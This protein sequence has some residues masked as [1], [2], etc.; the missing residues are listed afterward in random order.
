MINCKLTL[1]A[2]AALALLLPTLLTSCGDEDTVAV[3]ELTRTDVEEIVRS[4]V[5]RAT[6][7]SD[8]SGAEVERIVNEAVADLPQPE[9]TRLDVEQIVQSAIDAAMIQMSAQQS[10]DTPL[11]P[12]DVEQIVQAAIADLPESQPSLTA[13]EIQA[14]IQA[15][16]P[17]PGPTLAE[18]EELLRQA[19]SKA[20]EPGL[21][22]EEVRRLA[23]NAVASIP[24]RSSPAEFTKFFVQ[25]AISRYNEEGLPSTIAHYS[26]RPSVDGQ[27]FVFIVDENDKVIAHHNPGL[28]GEDL[29]GPFGVDANGYS[30]GRDFLSATEQGKWVSYVSRNPETG[31][32]GD[33]EIK[34]VWVVKQDD[35]LFASGWHINANDFTTQL[36]SVAIDAFRYGG[37]QATLDHFASPDSALAGLETA[38]AYYNQ[39]ESVDG[40]WSVFIANES[41]RFVAHSNP[42]L[43]GTGAEE[44]FGPEI[45]NAPESGTW[46]TT[47][48]SHVYVASYGGLIFGSGWRQGELEKASLVDRLK[49]NANEFDYAI[50]NF[51]GTLTFATISEPLTLNLAIASDASSSGVL[52][53]L[54]EGLTTT[55]WL[56]NKVEPSLAKSWQHS[57]DGLTWTFHLRDDVRWHD[58]EPFTAHD[59]AF[60]FNRIIYNP[61]I[62]AS[63]R[64]TF[65]FRTLNQETG[66]WEESPMTVR[67]LDD[68]TVEC[69]LPVP[70]A[71]FLRSMGTAI[72][73]RHI[74]ETHVDDG[75][76]TT[77]WDIETDPAEIIGTG[78]FTIDSYS[79]GEHVIMKRN[80]DYWLKDAEGNTLPY[81]DRIIH[82][83][84]SDLEEEIDKFLDGD[85]DVHGVL[86]EEI[87]ILAPLQKE[88]NF[89][90]H[91]RGPAFGTA[92]MSFNMNPGLNPDTGVPYLSPE[93]LEWFRNRQFRQAVAHVIDKNKIIHQ[94]QH[95]AG[96][97]QWSSVSPAAGDFHNPNVTQYE[98]DIDKA[99]QILDDLGWV[100]T[101]GNGIRE[102]QNGNEIKF[103]M[104]T[105]MGNSVR[106]QVGTIIH[107]GMTEIGLNVDY[108]TIEFGDLVSRLLRTY[109]WEAIVIGF[110]GGSDPHSGIT[111]WHSGEGLHLWY[112][113]QPEPATDWEAE[114]DELYIMASQE[115][116]RDRRI[117]LYHRAQEIAA[118]YLPLIYTTLS[119]RLTAVR[120]VFGNT[121]PTLYGLWDVRYLFK[122][123]E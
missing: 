56:T 97:L 113:N 52:G 28:I 30:F 61:D 100:D 17:E 104:V 88:Q 32:V 122:T 54:F 95:G 119:E 50:G 26:S 84:V 123:D 59:V 80:P 86:G 72:Y 60:T 92:F 2:F 7:A 36:V 45:F 19:I 10:V 85:A 108:K 120:N 82:D 48:S 46:I 57:Q 47:A 33:F 38:I 105:N 75:S 1:V 117:E 103:S 63:S 79:P 43:I 99:N 31:G 25:N 110:T 49:R 109:E 51:G 87:P 73:P 23:R 14:I 6:P 41:G 116:D 62:P 24:P 78:A 111:L 81:L 69:V 22:L 94:A 66:A 8:L 77:T 44:L 27:W 71:P 70:F 74:L 55:S 35:L 114:I 37:L 34:N 90:I 96:Y 42:E 107:E 4:E 13:G 101:N 106:E 3:S 39:A 98:Y 118:N 64:P 121:T 68:Y 91:R 16:M 20:V 58:G 21:T 89:T 15:S 76:F 40:Q 5:A 67:A 53:Y 83:I 29:N 11:T 9:L 115:L 65:H 102:D 18:V 93:K 112:P 12:T